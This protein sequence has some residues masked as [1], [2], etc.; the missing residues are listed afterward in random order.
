MFIEVS[1]F[2]FT[3]SLYSLIWL[4]EYKLNVLKIFTKFIHRLALELTF[5]FRNRNPV[6]EAKVRENETKENPYI[7]ELK[8]ESYGL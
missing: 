1:F 2:I 7:F 8:L 5:F 6:R 4:C 3:I